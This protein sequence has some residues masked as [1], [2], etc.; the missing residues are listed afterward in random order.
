MARA[1]RLRA[2]LHNPVVQVTTANL[3]SV[4]LGTISGVLTARGLGPDGRGQWAVVM[5]FFTVALVVA[6]LGQ[7]G[8]VTFLV[9]RDPRRKREVVRR[10]RI[11]MSIGGAVVALAG[12]LA[13]PVLAGGDNEAATAYRL[14]AGGIVINS[15]FAGG[16]FAMQGLDIRRWNVAR[17]AQP[18]F[19]ATGLSILL[20]LGNV[21]V[22]GAAIALVGSTSLQF[23]VLWFLAAG[24]EKHRALT[25]SGMD[26]GSTNRDEATPSVLDPGVS[27]EGVSQGGY[28]IRYAAAAVPTVLTAQYDKIALSRLVAPAEVG[29]YAVGA[30]V[31]LLV[32]PFSAAIANVAFPRA[33][34]RE[35]L[36]VERRS[37]EIRALMQVLVVSVVVSAGLCVVAPAAVPFFF[38]S[39]FA[40]SVRV[41]WALALVMVA[42]AIS[43][44]AGALIRARGLPGAA[45]VAQVAGLLI[46]VALMFPAVS[47]LGLL[48]AAVALG[49]GEFATLS[50][51]LFSLG[52]LQRADRISASTH[53]V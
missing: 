36:A 38:G 16:L 19:Y 21:T 8:A 7:S 43:Q 29:F 10:A 42:R 9:A 40:A 20:A 28:G 51:V 48:G 47:A 23:V 30:T 46:G 2:V 53:E 5:A 22:T 25:S 32:A 49:A 18:L 41:V 44:V 17:V 11:I 34:K 14:A 24:L 26:S 33:S 6:E 35:L 50:L 1:A 27:I 4:G 52:R 15:L 45:A 12:V 13:A 37:F 31:A 3:M 39:D